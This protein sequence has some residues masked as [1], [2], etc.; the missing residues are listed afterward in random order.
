MESCLKFLILRV[1]IIIALS[2]GT[3]NAAVV[4][5]AFSGSVNR[6]TEVRPILAEDGTTWS[7]ANVQKTTMPGYEVSVTEKIAGYFS[8]DTSA[9]LN[10]YWQPDLET[11]GTY[12]LYRGAGSSSLSF[13]RTGI[14]FTSNPSNS[15]AIMFVANDAS[16]FD[17]WD[18]FAFGTAVTS[19]NSVSSLVVS[20]IDR[21][22]TAFNGSGIPT[23]LDGRFQFGVP[24][25][26]ELRLTMD[27]SD[28]SQVHVEAMFD[29]LT[30]LSDHNEVPEP[31]SALVICAA[32]AAMAIARS[33]RKFSLKE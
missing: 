33:R 28:R 24:N 32:L 14:A 20:L 31:A 11:F 25:F 30:M 2:V 4:S 18:Y 7:F 6:I 16:S 21:N 15:E 13:E 23:D 3:A 17:R 26:P 5:Y 8:Y 27:F 19:P 22:A 29:S 9:P 1:L 10:D 12:L